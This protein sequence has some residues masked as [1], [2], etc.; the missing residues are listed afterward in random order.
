MAKYGNKPVSRE[1]LWLTFLIT[2]IITFVGLA[3]L[4]PPSNR[5][6]AE[7]LVENSI[8]NAG[9]SGYKAWFLAS[10]KSGLAIASWENG[11]DALNELPTPTTM[12]IVKPYTVTN[13]SVAFDQKE[14]AKLLQWVAKGN[15]LVLLDD[16]RRVGSGALL[17]RFQLN[18]SL[19]APAKLK[20]S[21]LKPALR[22]L[23]LSP[24]ARIPLGA[25]LK[26][27]LLSRN[28]AT[29]Q[30]GNSGI[31]NAEPILQD[32]QKQPVLVWLPYRKGRLILGTVTD[33]GENRYLNQPDNDNYQFLTNLLR[34]TNH[35]I[36]VNEFVHGY[37]ESGDLLSYFQKKT[38]LGGIFAQLMLFFGLLLWLGFV[39][40]KPL[41]TLREENPPP[42][43]GAHSPYI[44]SLAGLY[45]KSKSASLALTP[46]LK[47]LKTTLHQRH[48]INLSEEARVHDLL[49]S[50]FAH[51]SGTQSHREGD[52]PSSPDELMAAVKLAIRAT[53][54]KQHL[55]PQ[56]LL[57]TSR[58]L[59]VIEEI[60][61]IKKF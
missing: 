31:L 58:Q 38:P 8:H 5:S 15:T 4:L 2:G 61:N 25:F 48:G 7:A 22:S 36:V 20:P 26:A 13:D 46:Q 42:D 6:G 33:L 50:R 27:P 57:K 47:R 23:S 10:Q 21:K 17:E 3:A 1:A 55:T 35:P 51:Y 24:Q 44:D 28:T 52:I 12:L 59:T 19:P 45:I 30:A 14:T 9:P 39:R 37:A 56:T 40:W 18:V 11:F 54:T 29:L 43:Q 32:V 60:L 34:Q 49:L 41:A 16:F 53:E